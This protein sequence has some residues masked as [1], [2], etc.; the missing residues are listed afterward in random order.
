MTTYTRARPRFRPRLR[1]PEY[2][3]LDA[4]DCGPTCLRMVA[5]YWGRA[6]PLAEL[7]ERSHIGKQG[8][9]LLGIAYAA[10]SIGFRTLSAKTTEEGL[11]EA[12]LPLVAHWRQN[13]FVVVHG[14]RGDRVRVADPAE[15]PVT[16]SMKDFLAGWASGADPDTGRPSG[17]VLLLEP[18]P[19][20]FREDAEGP[21]RVGLPFLW[22]YVRG[23][24]R[25][26]G[27]VWLGVLAASVLQLVF[28]FLTQ[29]IVDHGITN[30]DLGFV[31][32]VLIAQLALFFSR[33]AVEFIRNRILFHVG[34]RVYVS[35]IS[36]FLQKLM[37]LPVPFFDT[38]QVGDILQRVQ[39]HA[40]VQ[41]F[42]T[43]ATLN[44][45]FSSLTLVAF[46]AVLALY[47]PLIFGV[48]AAGSAAYAGY[49]LLFLKRRRELD[50]LRFGEM[51]RSQNAIVEL[52]MA[53]PEIKLAN[54]EQQKRW[55]WERIQARLFRVSQSGL[56]LDQW[57]EGGAA[58]INELKNIA[59]TFLAA[60]LVIDGEMTLG[61]LLAVQYILGQLNAPLAQ[62]VGLVHGA[63]DA[64]TS[65]ERLGEIHGNPDEESVADR[66]TTL[67]S[68]GTITLR[69]VGFDYGGPLPAPVLQDLDLV[70]PQGKVTAIVGASGS[71][72]T[73]LLKLLLK[74]Y[75]PTRGEIT[76]G[77]AALRNLSNRAWR[78]G[79]G[80]VMQDGHL[81]ADS[82]ARNV[83]V[84]GEA[85]DPRRLAEAVR[86]ANVHEFV[87][88]L[89]IGYNTRVGRDGVGISQ[90][91]K[92]RL[93]IARAVYK[94]PA[95]LF[96]DEATSALD[97]NN[98][99]AIME[100]LHAFFRGRTV[101]VIAHR[102]STVR[103]ADQI[104]VLDKGRI[105]ERGTHDE[106]AARRGAY[107]ELVRNQLELGE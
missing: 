33:T 46:G 73:T 34:T 68:E 31:Y 3:Q 24:A 38:R 50:Y 12:P 53:M 72:K 39:D 67:P 82:I 81:F 63:Q 71:G 6:V 95:Y 94:D 25:Y 40:R 20:F 9:S 47:S 23:Y 89:P 78:Q 35:M 92:Q 15:G 86:T 59:T 57:Q 103:H 13:H 76:V 17:I 61:M 21:R 11:R 90:G 42:L 80:V 70:I 43:A 49:V 18:T 36:D 60:K 88:S 96:F 91:Q 56:S 30:Q 58:F 14:I 97:A 83:A 55:G 100:N 7:R 62:L 84:G 2:R 105:V 75:E 16:L 51:S 54:A 98:E 26:L 77:H 32:V 79:C 19:T 65:L 99:R 85:V 104:V 102:L 45:V 66:I 8:V 107:Y 10:E 74:F 37:K 106:L 69:G 29:A 64:R 93:L 48:F 4:M 5:K 22:Q 44:V 28:P 27:Q 41:Q 1:F 87:E 101:V 52:V